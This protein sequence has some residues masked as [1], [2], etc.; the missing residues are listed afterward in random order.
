M[1]WQL[2]KKYRRLQHNI[3]VKH[4]LASTCGTQ[5]QQNRGVT[6]HNNT[7]YHP[8]PAHLKM[9]WFIAFFSL[10]FFL[11]LTHCFSALEIEVEN[12]NWNG[13]LKFSI[14]IFHTPHFPHP[15]LRVV[16]LTKRWYNRINH[17]CMPCLNGNGKKIK[18]VNDRSVRRT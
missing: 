18:F 5:G 3:L 9:Q 14:R 11:L 15:A 12:W 2:T 8:S 7:Y 6:E 4:V 10:S 13:K 16:H 1:Q 17:V